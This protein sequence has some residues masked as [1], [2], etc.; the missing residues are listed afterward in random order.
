MKTSRSDA[1][2]IAVA[3]VA[4][5]AIAGTIAASTL[6][7]TAAGAAVTAVNPFADAGGF[8]VYVVEDANLDN[9]EI[10]GALAVGGTLRA[11]T[12]GS[13][14]PIVHYVAGTAAYTPPV[15]DGDTT[16]LLIGGFS[17]SSGMVDVTGAG[18]PSGVD[19]GY[20]KI[21][22]PVYQFT[23]RG[24]YVQ[25][26]S[27][28]ISG[29]DANGPVIEGKNH[30]WATDGVAKFQVIGDSVAEYVEQ[31]EG[32]SAVT[33]CLANLDEA[34]THH[35]AVSE[36][37]GKA[38]LSLVD[39]KV[40][41]VDYEDLFFWGSYASQIVYDGSVRPSATSPVIV[42]VPAGTETVKGSVFGES[43]E[44]ANYVMWDLSAITGAVTLTDRSGSST[45][46]DGSVYA[47]NADL[48]AYFGPLDGQVIARNFT[49]PA[50]AGE[51]HAY[52]FKGAVSC[53]LAGPSTSPS[54]SPSASTS[55]SP[56]ASSSASVSPSTSPSASPS[57]SVSPS[58]SP[59][60]STSVSAAPTASES[61]TPDPKSSSTETDGTGNELGDGDDGEGELST[62]G[63]DDIVL[64]Y[65]AAGVVVVGAL[66]IGGARRRGA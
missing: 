32:A 66:L 12:P 51:L 10:E 21:V 42:R 5:L 45:R 35:V 44:F 59:S 23:E 56:S 54:T 25:Y 62:T 6:T 36:D 49:A 19:G 37:G 55:A 28:A 61:A 24:G 47:P 34:S 13:R 39:N 33:Q 3:L 63:F 64:G 40:N 57:A 31:G 1:R 58:T 11:V 14:Y 22:N 53:E 27:T 41:I 52:M 46:I 2:P 48:T 20:A 8:S 16:R 60:A 50:G 9:T 18:A 30:V 43:G 7:G 65:V 29:S 4:T 15:I 26:R 38:K 17:L